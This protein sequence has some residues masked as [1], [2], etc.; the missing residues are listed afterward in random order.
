MAEADMAM[1][2]SLDAEE[3]EI[4]KF[5]EERNKALR[6]MNL[7]YARS[8]IPSAPSDEVL[9]VAL[10]KA[11]YECTG[12]EPEYRHASAAWLRERGYGRMCGPL[13]PEGELPE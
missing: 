13:L 4:A 8:V 5:R 7:D 6:E 2:R 3:L 12:L 11:R 1:S 9:I 10:H